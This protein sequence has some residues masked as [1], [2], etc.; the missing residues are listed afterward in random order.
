MGKV[1]GNTLGQRAQQIDSARALF[2]L[3]K[4]FHEL[5]PHLVVKF[6]AIWLQEHPVHIS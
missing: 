4:I 6:L 1:Q 5:L 2:T 3:S